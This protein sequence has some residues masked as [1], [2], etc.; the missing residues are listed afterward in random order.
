MRNGLARSTPFRLAI[1]L[2]TAFL[3]ALVI[4]GLTAFQLI[5]QELEVRIDRSVLDA[6]TV[7]GQSYGENDITDLTD[8]V[9]SH[10][11]ATQQHDKIYLL[12]DADGRVLAGNVAD[13]PLPAGWSTIS[14]ATL[15]VSD[16]SDNYRIH[17]GAIGPYRLLVGA[18]FGETNA[19][20]RLAYTSLAWA[21]ALFVA[22]VVITGLIVAARG[23]LRLDTIASTMQ[24]VG[25]GELGARIAITGRGDDIDA[26][27][28]E[29]NAALDRLAA[30][31]EG[32]RQVS[33]DIAHDLKTPLNRLA[34][35]VEAAI[36]A[37]EAGAPI[38]ALLA[39]AEE[40]S[41]Q[42]NTTFDAL[43]RIAQIEAGAR[44]ARFSTLAPH[45]IIATI[46]DAYGEVAVEQG[47]TLSVNAA[48]ALANI[49]GDKDL[50]VQM[51]A[52]LVENA[53]RHC[54]AGASITLGAQMV[55]RKVELAVADTGPGIA[56]AERGKVFQRLYRAEASRTT[57]GNGLGLS[58]V[59][60]VAELHGASVTLADNNP[61]LAVT[62]SFPP[63][64]KEPL[65]IL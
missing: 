16:A 63:G 41:R 1:I 42:I 11:N 46:A 56:Q 24:R 36:Q 43:L 49:D 2:G 29:V 59:K 34:I 64:G 22:I 65:T 45:D 6:Y 44:R 60:A 7:I 58:L 52:N 3:V 51:L 5:R 25:R 38:A 54:P 15:G 40:E 20:G 30:L 62:I 18:S 28:S 50:L 32:M 33:V 14:A 8:S 35:T 37:D 10:V 57:P 12:A 17:T 19:I 31:V 27:V 9:R 47:Q 4:A 21:A 23:Q 55:G 53:I 39:Q 61:G 26:L 48:D 13:T